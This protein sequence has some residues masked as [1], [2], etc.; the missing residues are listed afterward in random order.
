MREKSLRSGTT[1]ASHDNRKVWVESSLGTL[2]CQIPWLLHFSLINFLGG[3]CNL[4]SWLLKIRKDLCSVTYFCLI[5]TYIPL[6]WLNYIYAFFFFWYILLWIPASLQLTSLF[7][8]KKSLSYRF[9]LFALLRNH[10]I[11]EQVETIILWKNNL[12]VHWV[13]FAAF[14]RAIKNWWEKSSVSHVVKYSIR[15]K[16]CTHTLGEK[17]GTNFPG[18]SNSMDFTAF[19]HA[20][21]NWWKSPRI[22]QIMNYTI[23]C[24]SNGKEASIL[25]K[26]YEYQFHS[27]STY[28]GFCRIFPG[29][30]FPGFS[31]LTCFHAFAHAMENRWE[32]LC[33]FHVMKFNIK[34]ESNGKTASIRREKYEYQ[35]LRFSPC[36][37][38]C[39]IFLY[40]GKLMGKPMHFPYA[41]LSHRMGIE[42]EESSHA[43]GNVWVSIF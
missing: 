4:W 43:M 23:E 22:S 3:K 12:R 24:E 6:F 37:G 21:G 42:W 10:Q 11:L 15:W 20:L 16:K 36:D 18:S 34:W 25:Q 5:Y 30:N 32:N 17:M 26:K 1:T 33:I 7:Y 38:F 31:H 40:Y 28:D 35:F 2:S 41:E 8:K 13:D 29:T 9:F 39:C 19:S 14:S 27:F